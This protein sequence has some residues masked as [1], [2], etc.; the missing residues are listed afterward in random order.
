MTSTPSTSPGGVLGAGLWLIDYTKQID[1]YPE[2]SR[3]AKISRVIPSNGGGA[4]NVL[5]N[6]AKL[7]AN[8]PLRG[9]GRIG[10]DSNGRWILERCQSH[11][12]DTAG[13]KVTPESSTAFTDVMTESGSGRR[14]FFYQPGANEKLA[15]DDFDFQE[16]RERIFYL[17]YPGLLPLLDWPGIDG[18]SGIARVLAEARAAGMQTAV[19]CVSADDAPWEHL[20]LTLPEID[21]LFVNEWEAARLLNR[22]APAEG[23]VT[24]D[25]LTD[26]AVVLLQHG[27]R[28]AV[29]AHTSAGAALAAKDGTRLSLGA[30]DVPAQDIQGTCGA[31]D[32]LAAGVLLGLHRDQAWRDSLELGL[33]AA[34]MCL[35]DLTTSDALRPAGECLAYGRRLG[36]R[37]WT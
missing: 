5:I 26:A 36:H 33:C 28:R 7:G 1:R 12:V 13:L 23:R 3:L 27:V 9:L 25:E 30:I 8:V 6:L 21:Y 14:T 22:M 29:I 4:F 18:R 11:G 34:A 15:E 20:R 17:G 37:V 16:R 2:P 35:R 19:D 24:A 31:G 10:D 32:A